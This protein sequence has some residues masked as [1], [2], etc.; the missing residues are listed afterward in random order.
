MNKLSEAMQRFS[1]KKPEPA[2]AKANR[3]IAEITD[4]IVLKARDCLRSNIFAKYKKS[5]AEGREELIKI[6][7]EAREKV[8]DPIHYAEIS[9]SIFDRLY[10]FNILIE[11]VE[12]D[13][14]KQTGEEYDANK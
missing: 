14:Q 12:I 2:D 7:I 13:A 1:F 6:G 3:K 9:R 8:S 4:S 11:D 5:Y 10:L